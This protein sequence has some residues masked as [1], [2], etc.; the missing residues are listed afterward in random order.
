MLKRELLLQGPRKG[1]RASFSL[2][3]FSAG[4]GQRPTRKSLAQV[5][6]GLGKPGTEQAGTWAAAWL[7]TIQAGRPMPACSTATA[8]SSSL[9]LTLLPGVTGFNSCRLQTF[10][11]LVELGQY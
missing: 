6:L 5:C 4:V 8:S 11:E 10:R 9:I 1:P 7:D 3:F 2:W